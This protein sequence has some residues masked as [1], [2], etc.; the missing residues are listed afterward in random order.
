MN[1]NQKKW[2]K[3]VIATELGLAPA[4]QKNELISTLLTV[5]ES[6]PLLAES[7][8]FPKL[9]EVAPRKRDDYKVTLRK[10]CTHSQFSVVIVVKRR[11][12][13]FVPARLTMTQKS[14]QQRLV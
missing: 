9:H 11:E 6:S 8:Q 13:M 14:L 7:T 12:I 5:L 4:L 10:R 1:G 3:E 2:T